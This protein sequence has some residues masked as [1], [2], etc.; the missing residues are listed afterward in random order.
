[1]M[2]IARHWVLAALLACG[3]QAAAAA[4][5]D[6]EALRR[7]LF[8]AANEALQAANDA[9]ASLLAPTS[10]SEGARYYRSAETTLEEG[11]GIESIR[12]DLTRAEASFRAAAEHCAV[13][14]P[15]F[16]TVL[17]AREDALSADAETYAPGDW[18]EAEQTFNDAA[19]RLERGRLKSAQKGAEEAEQ[20][21]REAELSAIKTN[22][23]EETASLLEQAEELRAQRYAPQSFVAAQS[24]LEEAEASLNADRYDTDRPRSLASEAKHNA[25]HAIYVSR[26]ERSIRDGDTSLEQI[27]LDW[28]ASLR[29]IANMVD[30]PVYF[31]AGQD[32]AVTAIGDRI[33]ELTNEKQQLAD[34]LRDRDAQLLAMGADVANLQR[35]KDLAA[36]QDR[37]REQVKA[38]ENLFEPSQAIVLR[39]GNSII[40]R[41]IGLNFDSGS[42]VLKP[43]H[44]RLLGILE[45]AI[46]RFPES[47]IV[48]EGHTD[49][50]GSDTLNQELSQKRADA[51]QEYL[52]NN[53]PISPASITAL[54]YGE[55]HPVANN[56]TPEGRRSNRRIDVVINP[57]W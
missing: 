25:L 37:Q 36:R 1:M 47:T 16:E 14:A 18:G 17:E 11:G 46:N 42:A 48:I 7:S 23:L 15:A 38:V 29:S 2:K 31:D 27:L 35:I 50:F 26:L 20:Q 30:T 28:E 13:A 53:S 45:S 8:A 40:I 21:Y 5:D 10:Y 54:G 12:R 9:R 52:L 43:E 3:G 44:Y 33:T 51:V 57:R 19:V 41:M 34:N 22:Y 55:T 4:P 24:L 32:A 49:S 39:Q 6:N 56:E